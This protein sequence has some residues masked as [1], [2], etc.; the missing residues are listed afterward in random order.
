MLMQQS[1][2]TT[3][4]TG[5]T[6][7]EV[8]LRWFVK[9]FIPAAKAHGNPDKPILLIYNGHFSHVSIKMINATMENNIILYELLSHT[10]HRL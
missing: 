2:I 5:W 4:G 3:T 9:N 6:S 8:C 1:R 10:T 7:S